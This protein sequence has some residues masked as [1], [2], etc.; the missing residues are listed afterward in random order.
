M[1]LWPLRATGGLVGVSSFAVLPQIQPA[2][3]AV[4]VVAAMTPALARAWRCPKPA[5]FLDA[6]TYACLCSFVFG[7]HVHEKAILMVPSTLRPVISASRL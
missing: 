1:K 6:V 7:Y 4:L 3:T 5:E 2:H